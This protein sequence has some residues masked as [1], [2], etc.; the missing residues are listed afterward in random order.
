MRKLYSLL[1][2]TMF[3]AQCSV[4]SAQTKMQIHLKS[5][6]VVDYFVSDIDSVSFKE[7]ASMVI[8][9]HRF[10]DL[11]LPSG[12]LWAETNLEAD[13]PADDG[14]YYAWGETEPKTEYSLSSYKWYDGENMTKYTVAGETLDADDDAAT[15]GWGSPCR[16]PTIQEIFELCKTDYCSW[17]WTSKT[18]SDGSSISGYEVT[19]KKTGNSI[20]LPASGRYSDKN[21]S[22]HGSFGFYWS[23]TLP[24]KN[25]ADAHFLAFYENEWYSNRSNRANGRSVRPVALP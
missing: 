15:V 9:G 3:V 22:D 2:C 10:V 18:A 24:D 8:N 4:V 19:G 25:C 12:V 5:G 23:S 11:G 13:V 17:V 21:F 14:T 20:F 6:S 1:Y 16:I 7:D